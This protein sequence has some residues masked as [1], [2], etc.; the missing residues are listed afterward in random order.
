M[1]GER[2]LPGLGLRA[3]WTVGSNNWDQQHDP[4]TRKL[5]VL[6]QA[7]VISRTTNL[8]GS[9]SNG[10]IYIV[11]V[12]QTNENQI[13]ARDNGAWVYF[14]PA[15]G[16]LVHVNDDDE[17]VKWTGSAWVAFK[18]GTVLPEITGKAGK[19][20]KVN[21][22][23]TGLLWAD[24]LQGGGDGP[25]VDP[26]YEPHIYWRLLAT[27]GSTSNPFIR[28]STLKFI[29]GDGNNI[30]VPFSGVAISDTGT[31]GNAFDSNEGT[32]WDS[33]RLSNGPHYVGW[34]FNDATQVY[35]ATFRP[36]ESEGNVLRGFRLEFSDDGAEWTPALTHAAGTGDLP[37]NVYSTFYFPRENK[38]PNGGAAGAVLT[39]RSADDFDA[40]W[41]GGAGT[42]F[43][44]HSYW[45][46]LVTAN[47]GDDRFV[48]IAEMV[49]QEVN[50]VQAATGGTALQSGNYAGNP[51]TNAFDGNPTSVWKSQSGSVAA[52]N[53]W[54]GYQ[55]TAPVEIKQITFGNYNG[56][57]ND[58]WMTAGVV[59][60]SDDGAAWTDAWS[61]TLDWTGSANQTK[62]RKAA[63]V[64]FPVRFFS[65]TTDAPVAGDIGKL[66]I[67]NN[68]TT[69]TSTI[70]L[71]FGAIGD[72]LTWIANGAGTLNI[73]GAA[74]VT[75]NK[76]DGFTAQAKGRYTSVSAIKTAANEWV[77]TG[78][79][80]AA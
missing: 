5:S 35:G 60:Y 14:A 28:V 26:I 31:A 20:L 13:A 25:A 29:D 45:R 76:P 38:L 22:G 6:V 67:A 73:A 16:F 59:Q 30:S 34:Q 55:F 44:K 27:D 23:A 37:N 7:A 36:V 12:G 61:F 65:G 63:G 8:P 74:G 68:A 11:P 48:H 24:D 4:D 54:L 77:L 58:E 57:E 39:K 62:T 10:D 71:D 47:S 3:Y 53:I 21:A 19:V 18:P 64:E 52:R 79:L 80:A 17:F 32:Y 46:V 42:S 40:V 69:A 9:P 2:A 51:A 75:V 56:Y 41:V 78:A 33:A 15:E 72:V 1:A 49:M 50:G 66:I 43:G 70:P